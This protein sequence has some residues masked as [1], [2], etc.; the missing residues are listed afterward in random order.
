M[1]EILTRYS[2]IVRLRAESLAA[3]QPIRSSLDEKVHQAVTS[4]TTHEPNLR[5]TRSV[6]DGGNCSIQA[7]ANGYNIAIATRSGQDS[8][9]QGGAPRTFV[10]YSLS[11]EGTLR[12]L[13]RAASFSREMR[14]ILRGGG[15]LLCAFLFFCGIDFLFRDSE[16][17]FIH[18]PL[19]LVV[20][21]VIAGGWLGE[22][23]GNILGNKLEARA[24]AR[25]ERSGALPQ[26]EFLWTD[27]ERRF[28][29]LLQSH[30][31][32]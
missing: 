17:T 3:S 12:S 14:V 29:M 13:D 10:S 26:L 20:V 27:L 18:I 28:N 32:V 5:I 24:C 22:R 23:L 11:A 30:D 8:V 25:A 2:K 1:G 7:S 15:G 16:A 19:G 4:L 31:Q 21:I 6:D 9:F